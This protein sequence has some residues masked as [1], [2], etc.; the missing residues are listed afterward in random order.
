MDRRTMLTAFGGAGAGALA[1]AGQTQTAQAQAPAAAG[2]LRR[3]LDRG[4]L[5]VGTRSTTIG[6]GFRDARGEL[7]GFDIDLARGIA[8]GIFGDDNNRIEFEVF[9]GGAERIPALQTGR[10]DIVVSQFSVSEARAQV[11]EFSLPYCNSDFGAMVRANSPYQKHE[12]LNGRVVTTRQ[13]TV[14]QQ[15]IL[16]AIPRARVEM[17]PNF[18]DSFAAFRQGRAE[19][20]F[21]DSA[22]ARYIMQEFPGQFRVIYDPSNAIDVNQFSIGIR[23]GD[24]QLLNYINWAL[25]RMR[26]DGRLEGYHKKWLQ[27]TD[28]MPG[29]SKIPV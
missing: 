6:F 10:V 5:I 15:M 7:V 11:I 1:M 2:G 29:W 25:T 13:D 8:R 28:M 23:Q 20:F 19:A 21:N 24:Q 26:L 3:I 22:P 9:P 16:G 12:D 27:S 17:Y 18:S 14:S 4:R